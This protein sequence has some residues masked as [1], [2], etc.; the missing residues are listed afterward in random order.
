MREFECAF[1]DD[2]DQLPRKVKVPGRGWESN[3]LSEAI[4]FGTGV[5]KES[6]PESVCKIPMR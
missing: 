2:L 4:A 6:F 3:F 5:H 1:V